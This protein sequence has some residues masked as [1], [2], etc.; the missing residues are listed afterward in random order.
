ML[1]NVNSSSTPVLLATKT[2]SQS[3]TM[4]IPGGY[5]G[6]VLMTKVPGE[7][8]TRIADLGLDEREEFRQSFKR[9][10]L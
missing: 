8:I 2:T 9:G 7:Q 6:F 5:L 10:W 1:A 4:W 3:D